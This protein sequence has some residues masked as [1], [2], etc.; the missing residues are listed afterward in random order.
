MQTKELWLGAAY[1]AASVAMLYL[2]PGAF[3]AFVFLPAALLLALCIYLALG[4]GSLLSR[5]AAFLV[6]FSA[7]VGLFAVHP[8]NHSTSTQ[9]IAQCGKSLSGML[10]VAALLSPWRLVGSIST[11]V[12]QSQRITLRGLTALLTLACVGA[13]GWSWARVPPLAVRFYWDNVVGSAL[14]ASAGVL[15]ALGP[16]RVWQVIGVFCAVAIFPRHGWVGT[17]AYV[18]LGV[19]LFQLLN[20]LWTMLPLLILRRWGYLLRR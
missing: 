3:V 14:L 4:P 15:L 13:A 9:V 19:A 2:I 17:D 1:A 7:L 12:T 8:S 5:G 18:S 11:A 16:T 10:F 20:L 6:G